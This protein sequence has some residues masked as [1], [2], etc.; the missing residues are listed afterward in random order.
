M[1]RIAPSAKVFRPVLGSRFFHASS[2]ASDP[3]TIDLCPEPEYDTGC[4]HCMPQSLKDFDSEK[5]KKLNGTRAYHSKHFM[6]T[7]GTKGGYLHET[8]LPS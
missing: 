1:I 2:F 7:T 8:W 6:L 5:R 3:V 4:T